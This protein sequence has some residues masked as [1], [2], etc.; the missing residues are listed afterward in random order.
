LDQEIEDVPMFDY[1]HTA[2]LGSGSQTAIMPESVSA[3]SGNDSDSDAMSFDHTAYLG[4]GSQTAIMPE[5]VSAASGNDFSDSDSDAMSFNWEDHHYDPE[6]TDSD[7]DS[8]SNLSDFDIADIMSRN[9]DFFNIPDS[10]KTLQSDLLGG[11]KLPPKPENMDLDKK[12]LS[13]SE[14]AS[15]KHFSAWNKSN[16]TVKAYELHKTVLESVSGIPILSLHMV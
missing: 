16:G 15:L 9:S 10:L 11:Y 3:A 1:D 13:I 2:Y 5:S 7:S 14:M 6:S 4:S 12:P 8:D